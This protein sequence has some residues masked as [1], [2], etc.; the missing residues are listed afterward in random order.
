MKMRVL[1]GCVL[2]LALAFSLSANY[3][4]ERVITQQLRQIANSRHLTSGRSAAGPLARLLE[5][6]G[7]MPN[8]ARD[9]LKSAQAG[10]LQCRVRWRQVMTPE[11]AIKRLQ[12]ARSTEDSVGTRAV[13]EKSPEAVSRITG[14]IVVSRSVA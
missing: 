14:K 10:E 4:L 5:A 1:L 9:F 6:P 13:T 12:S 7:S 3:V 8:L 2:A 11:P